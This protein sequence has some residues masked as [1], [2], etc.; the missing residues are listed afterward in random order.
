MRSYLFLAMVLCLTVVAVLRRG[1]ESAVEPLPNPA[2][3]E[4]HVPERLDSVV[5]IDEA[6][7]DLDP[8][9]IELFETTP[10]ALHRA[11]TEGFRA[12][13]GLGISRGGRHVLIG[14]DAVR[15]IEDANAFSDERA[16]PTAKNP[17][18][19]WGALGTRAKDAEHP[20]LSKMSGEYLRG[21][22]SDVWKLD[23]V[24]LVSLD[25]FSQ[26]VAYDESELP[27]MH[28]LKSDQVPTRLLNAFETQ[29]AERLRA[30]ENLIVERTASRVS[31]LG[32][33]RASDQCVDC[34]AAEP[35]ELLGAFT[36]HLFR[37]D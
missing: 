21:Q 26:P 31:M 13:D 35:D 5:S 17:Y 32:A 7:I 1:R 18:G 16:D 8:L 20:T 11:N 23:L 34:H 25:R 33:I 28:C 6:E 4:V 30:G 10:D 15:F 2:R 22:D 36:Y 24:Q 19:M 9:Q 27:K 12:A 3:S 29:A 14:D 37:H